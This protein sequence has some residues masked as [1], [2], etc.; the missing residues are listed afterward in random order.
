MSETAGQLHGIISR[1]DAWRMWAPYGERH[2]TLNSELDIYEASE[3]EL[4]SVYDGSTIRVA[5]RLANLGDAIDTAADGIA[6]EL[7]EQYYDLL[8]QSNVRQTER[9]V[10]KRER[11]LD[12][13]HDFVKTIERGVAGLAREGL[14]TREQAEK[15]QGWL[16]APDGTPYVQHVPLTRLEY[17]RLCFQYDREYPSGNSENATFFVNGTTVSVHRLYKA[18]RRAPVHGRVHETVHAMLSGLEIYDTTRVD[19]LRYPQASVIGTCVA[20]PTVEVIAGSDAGSCDNS[21]LNEGWTDLIAR[22]LMRVEPALG[23]PM[24]KTEGYGEWATTMG[25]LAVDHPK[26][27]RMITNATLLDVEEV[28]RDAKHGAIEDTKNYADKVLD[29]KDAL[30]KRFQASGGKYNDVHAKDRDS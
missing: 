21:E 3:E 26:L 30:T 8:Q 18:A 1:E 5:D 22:E 14:F 9:V 10:K 6:E 2:L 27:Y 23:T 7:V 24:E 29:E 4:K 11:I 17:A 13:E 16:W 28:G 20:P 12:T 25:R 19:G 15:L